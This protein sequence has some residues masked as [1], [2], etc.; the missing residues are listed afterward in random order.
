VSDT[1]TRYKL[2]LRHTSWNGWDWWISGE[3][4]T[5]LTGGVTRTLWQLSGWGWSERS[6]RRKAHKQAL[7]EIHPKRPTVKFDTVDL[8]NE[9]DHE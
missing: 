2:T 6:A 1:A 4:D 7:K 9:I 5:G 8:Q 3:V